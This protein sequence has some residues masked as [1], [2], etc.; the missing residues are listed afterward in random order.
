MCSA[1]VAGVVMLVIVPI[2]YIIVQDQ[3]VRAQALS[4]LEVEGVWSRHSGVHVIV[5]L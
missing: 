4:L 3:P 1:L 5:P 2:L